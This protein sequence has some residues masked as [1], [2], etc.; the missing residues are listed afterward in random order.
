MI[1]KVDGLDPGK[2]GKGKPAI[3]N[4][5]K[6]QWKTKIKMLSTKTYCI[7]QGTLLNVASRMGG[8]FGG[9]WIYVWLSPFAEHLKLS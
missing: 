4:K 3:Q 5:L 1:R 8:Q 2:R 9:D 6:G 7:A